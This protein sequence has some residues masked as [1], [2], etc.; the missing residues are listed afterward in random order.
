MMFSFDYKFNGFH[1]T[2]Y[3][4][5]LLQESLP[6]KLVI[7][8][9]VLLWLHTHCTLTHKNGPLFNFGNAGEIMK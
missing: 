6:H 9:S 2:V 3:M 8:N 7:C 1:S 4:K 5:I